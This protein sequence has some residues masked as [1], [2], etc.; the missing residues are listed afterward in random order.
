M[1]NKSILVS[2]GVWAMLDHYSS[3]PR[4]E[5]CPS[6]PKSWCPLNRDAANETQ[7]HRPTIDPLRP[8]V[9]ELM[10]P[11][12]TRLG[13]VSF[14]EACS[15]CYTQNT[16]ESLH[17]VIWSMAPKDVYSSPAETSLAISLAVCQYNS[18]FSYTTNNI[19]YSINLNYTPSMLKA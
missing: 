9:R 6:G 16:N 15:N 12:F 8:A 3:P 17:H 4:H 18:G 7:L 10:I 13:K 2:K 5:H 11:L 1:R 19:F 14:L